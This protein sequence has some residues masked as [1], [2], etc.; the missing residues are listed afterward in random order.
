MILNDIKNN[1]RILAFEIKNASMVDNAKNAISMLRDQYQIADAIAICSDNIDGWFDKEFISKYNLMT[2]D[3]PNECDNISKI[4]NYILNEFEK[5][6]F[7][8]FVHLIEDNVI[9]FKD[10]KEYIDCVEKTMDF[11]DYDIY[12]STVTDPC[13]YVY[14]KFNPR[15][16]LD[17]DDASLVE[18]GISRAISFTSH[19]N[20]AYTIWNFANL[21]Q[22]GVPKFNENFS[23]AMYMIIEFL[24]RRK[25]TKNAGQ[26]YFMNQYLSVA[27]ENKTY[28]TLDVKQNISKS[29]MASEDA[30][31]KSLNVN[32]APD[33]NIDHILDALYSKMCSKRK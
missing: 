26:L 30:I 21:I 15:I 29:I 24:A 22:N 10:P 11:L 3:V 12:F 19:S 13:N 33:N 23:I 4:K 14:S 7:K 31:F 1:N 32:H 2:I 8:G 6:E 17:I 27:E 18:C 28:G 9:F 25:N 5:V 20:T 16:T